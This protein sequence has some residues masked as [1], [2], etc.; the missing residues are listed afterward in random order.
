MAEKLL[1]IALSPT[2]EDGTIGTWVKKEGDDIESGDIICEVE[3]DKA[4]M[5]YESTQEGRLLK[6][7]VPEGGSATVGRPIGIIGEEG[8]EIDGLVNEAEEELAAGG[9]PAGGAESPRGT[10]G[11]EAAAGSGAGERRAADE[12]R[13][14]GAGVAGGGT[15]AGSGAAAGGH[16]TPAAPAASAPGGHVKSS[17]LARVLADKHGIDI[18]AVR[19]SG[20]EGRV[21]KRDVEKAIQ[22]QTADTGKAG[23]SAPGSGRGAAGTPAP[24]LP[25]Y[26]ATETR[27]IS[28]K[29]RII[30]RRLSESKFSAPHYY[31]KI[32][33]AV[34]SLFA[35]RRDLNRSRQED[36]VSFNSFLIKLAAE[37]LKK[38]PQ[39]RSGW[40]EDS[41]T[42]FGNI[43]IGI[44]VA[45]K[46]G[47]I[48]PVVRACES[49]GILQID[50]ELKELIQRARSGKLTPDEYE[51]A[52]FTISNLGSYGIEEF[53]A[54]INPP[55][56]AILAVG[57]VQKQKIYDEDEEGVL[58]SMLKLTLSCDHRVVDGAVGALFLRD[59]K[60]SLENPIHALY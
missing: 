13:T 6:I 2:M 5:D 26:I 48:T 39:V 43:D 35:A 49:K 30:A 54:I 31:L 24:G 22:R 21:V 12:G 46:D 34:D 27:P 59:F 38:H 33:A 58:K 15:K 50:G 23:R 3:T 19:G 41:I 57:A 40:Q 36:K 55:G 45:Q 16:G 56:S 1:M 37:T 18:G 28:Q 42:T 10:A 9:S 52:V 14:A 29:R 8:E 7:L 51:N 25:A 32:S 47:L 20:P 60:D 17:P 44:A 4:T 11:S 53:T